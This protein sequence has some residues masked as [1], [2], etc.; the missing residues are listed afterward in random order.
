MQK[1]CLALMLSAALSILVGDA[2]HAQNGLSTSGIFGDPNNLAKR[3]NGPTGKPC[4]TIEGSAKPQ[5]INPNIFEHWVSA[6][7][8]CGQHI[9]VNICYFQTQHCVMVDV[10]PWDR[11][12]TVLGIFP[13]LRDFRY[14]YTEQFY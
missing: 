13:A 4:I 11:K 3:H 6:A 9:K 1:L 5:T 2:V 10:P 14:D 7:N 12:D 8:S